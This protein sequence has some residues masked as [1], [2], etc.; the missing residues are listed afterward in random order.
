MGFAQFDTRFPQL[1][2]ACGDEDVPV[3]FLEFGTLV[4]GNRIFQRQRMQPEFIAQTGDGLA[5]GRFQLDPDETIRLADMLAD[6]VERD[7]LGCGI[8]EDQAVDDE[9]RS[10]GGKPIDS[11]TG[12]GLFCT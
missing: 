11:R 10:E 6:V 7:G 1:R 2:G 9:L 4:G 3:V 5:V 12:I 8:V